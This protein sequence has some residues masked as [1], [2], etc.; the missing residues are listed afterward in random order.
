MVFTAALE[1][2]GQKV[3]VNKEQLARFLSGKF[4]VS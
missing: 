2:Y 3:D 1:G 4:S